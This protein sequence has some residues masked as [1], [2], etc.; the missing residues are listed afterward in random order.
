MTYQESS[1]AP[2]AFLTEEEEAELI[3]KMLAGCSRSRERLVLCHDTLVQKIAKKY[4]PV[5]RLD[6]EDLVSEGTIGLLTAADRFGAE[7]D[8]R[9]STYALWWVRAFAREF[10]FRQGADIRVSQETR[11]LLSVLEKQS[12]LLSKKLDRLPTHQELADAAGIS[13]KVLEAA[14]LYRRVRV[15]SFNSPVKKEGEDTTFL[16]ITPEHGALNPEDY[17]LA[18]SELA[19]SR[20]QLRSAWKIAHEVYDSGKNSARDMAIF[21]R[22]HKHGEENHPTLDELAVSNNV[23][24]ERIRKVLERSFEEIR[25]QLGV[26]ADNPIFFLEAQIASLEELVST[27]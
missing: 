8:N 1:T 24:R 12:K 20:R 2:A 26:T 13:L 4:L 5:G 27:E 14:I 6:L 17:C 21:T 15:S 23:S 7:K 18:K 22:Y 11:D 3:G 19:E 16:D 10:A 25:I 9:F